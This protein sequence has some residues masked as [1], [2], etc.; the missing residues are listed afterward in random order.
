MKLEPIIFLQKPLPS[1]QKS[2]TRNK[3]VTIQPSALKLQPLKPSSQPL[4]F[5]PYKHE[6]VSSYN[7]PPSPHTE[8]VLPTPTEGDDDKPPSNDEHGPLTSMVYSSLP[9]NDYISEHDYRLQESPSRR[10]F[11]FLS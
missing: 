10:S 7:D 1:Q 11:H 3:P 4:T 8:H 6:E 2:F 9:H 5:E